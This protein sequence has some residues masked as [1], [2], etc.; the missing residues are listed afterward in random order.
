MTIS[1]HEY[2][3]ETGLVPF[4]DQLKSK[5]YAAA[6]E[7]NNKARRQTEKIKRL[8]MAEAPLQYVSLCERVLT[9][10]DSYIRNRQ[11]VY[12]PYVLKLSDK[13]AD[14]HNCA[15][16]TGNCK[17]E[18]DSHVMELN[19]TNDLI[20]QVLSKLKMASLPLYSETTFPDEFRVLRAHMTLLEN[21]LT[22][23]VFLENNYLIPKIREA[24]K[25]INAL[26]K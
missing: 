16:C 4:A 22:E 11:S 24:Q 8:E 12:L 20:R 13:V 7:I 14:D 23:L 19:A 26:N 5:Y 21:H 18:H 10:T 25:S 3:R 15:N 17:L 6:E 1:T 2:F 9:E